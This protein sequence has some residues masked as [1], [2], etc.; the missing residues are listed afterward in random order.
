MTGVF[1]KKG[2]G[3]GATSLPYA[4]KDNVQKSLQALKNTKGNN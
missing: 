2:Q 3:E 4:I 1:S